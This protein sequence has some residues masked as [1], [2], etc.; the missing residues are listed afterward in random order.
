MDRETELY[1]LSDDE[2]DAVA[3][4]QITGEQVNGG[5]NT[6]NGQANG[7]PEVFSNP[8]GYQPPGQN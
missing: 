2:L 3:G 7:V 8:A 4:G 5:G 1:E 6:P